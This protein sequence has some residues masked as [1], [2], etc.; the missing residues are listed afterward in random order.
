MLLQQYCLSAGAVAGQGR[1]QGVG[2]KDALAKLCS[3]MQVS[4]QSPARERLHS[5]Y[6]VS[7]APMIFVKAAWMGLQ[8]YP[9]LYSGHTENCD[10]NRR[11]HIFS[12]WQSMGCPP[13]HT[14]RA[15]PGC[16]G[17]T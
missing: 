3:W 11:L 13:M 17:L 1:T 10:L 4:A 6:H 9:V 5:S 14:C 15:L 12:G 8:R 2:Y 16:A 7:H